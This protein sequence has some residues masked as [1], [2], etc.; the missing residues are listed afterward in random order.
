MVVNIVAMEV[1]SGMTLDVAREE[2]MGSRRVEMEMNV[3]RIKVM[4]SVTKC[5]EYGHYINE[6]PTGRSKNKFN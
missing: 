5:G 1:Q 2:V 4:L 3:S 6:C